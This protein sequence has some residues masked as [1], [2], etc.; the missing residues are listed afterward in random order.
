MVELDSPVVELRIRLSGTHAVDADPLAAK[1]ARGPSIAAT[2]FGRNGTIYDI[3]PE[4]T[5][6]RTWKGRSAY[7]AA[8]GARSEVVVSIEGD[9]LRVGEEAV[10]LPGPFTEIAFMESLIVVV[11]ERPAE[12]VNTVFGVDETGEVVWRIRAPEC[13][14][15]IGGA[16]PYVGVGVSDGRLSV[17]D[18]WGREFAVDPCSGHVLDGILRVHH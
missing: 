4:G 5:L 11:A 17:I 12:D 18:F 9:R 6:I 16:V 13:A 15:Q 10:L 7:P 8:F 1:G 14:D 3:S 2:A